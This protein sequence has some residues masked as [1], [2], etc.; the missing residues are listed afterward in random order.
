M[1]VGMRW[2]VASWKQ[3]VVTFSCAAC[4]LLVAL[5][6]G[7]FG[8]N[9][10]E[11]TSYSAYN[12]LGN[13]HEWDNSTCTGV[14]LFKGQTW[15][16]V[17]PVLKPLN[18]YLALWF[19]PLLA[20]PQHTDGDVDVQLRVD[21]YGKQDVGE[22]LWHHVKEY[23]VN[24]VVTCSDER[25][26]CKPITIM[27]Q[28]N[29]QFAIYQ[30][31]V[32]IV[33]WDHTYLFGDAELQFVRYNV[34]YSLLELSLRSL[35]ITINAILLVKFLLVMKGTLWLGWT[36]RQK[37]LLLLL[38]GL[39][40]FNNP[41]FGLQFIF[42]EWFFRYVDAFFT[43]T[44]IPVYITFFCS[45]DKHKD[46]FREC[47]SNFCANIAI[48]LTA[49]W[50]LVYIMWFTWMKFW[51]P[52]LTTTDVYPSKHPLLII[53]GIPLVALLYWVPLCLFILPTR[54]LRYPKGMNLIITLTWSLSCIGASW[55]TYHDPFGHNAAVVIYF[56]TFYNVAIW[57][58]ACGSFPVSVYEPVP[59]SEEDDLMGSDQL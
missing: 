54:S 59:A 10:F 56:L 9:M 2:Q 51:D 5:L 38:G 1:P 35:F 17:S 27:D 21:I 52:L 6:V 45:M 34:N 29:L 44:F 58:L 33:S 42:H 7:L 49:C 22:D 32:K 30:V 39:L 31:H 23:S 16:K 19:T 40:V 12:C 4:V 57:L 28:Q 13:S 46:K 50:A 14:Q 48:V 26:Q 11:I 3:I 8:P 24:D 37:I 36:N 15:L 41:L 18:G 55:G 25:Q 20:A 43:A 53:H 47:V